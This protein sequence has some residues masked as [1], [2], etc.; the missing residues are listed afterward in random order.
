MLANP[1]Q[2]A[3]WLLTWK[4]IILAFPS[5]FSGFWYDRFHKWFCSSD[6]MGVLIAL[7]VASFSRQFQNTQMQG[8]DAIAITRIS[9]TRWRGWDTCDCECQGAFQCDVNWI[10]TERV[11]GSH[12]SIGA[13]TTRCQTND[14]VVFI[15]FYEVRDDFQGLFS[16]WAW[17][18]W[19][20]TSSLIVPPCT[21]SPR[22][23]CTLS[24]LLPHE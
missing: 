3:N 19:N 24:Y 12:I 9:S 11:V 17:Q 13:L 22:V 1:S 10:W 7:Y 2:E 8:P 16:A 23:N 18:R 5:L 14:K 20:V 15:I 21:L 4:L 6:D